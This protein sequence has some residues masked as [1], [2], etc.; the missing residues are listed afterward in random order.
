MATS[1]CWTYIWLDVPPAQK[2]ARGT[3]YGC[4]AWDSLDW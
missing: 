2:T 4:D 1:E 3:R